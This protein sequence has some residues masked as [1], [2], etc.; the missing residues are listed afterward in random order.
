MKK[1]LVQGYSTSSS[2][3]PDSAEEKSLG[4]GKVKKFGKGPEYTEN[5]SRLKI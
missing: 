3:D 1:R 4:P 5:K 2:K